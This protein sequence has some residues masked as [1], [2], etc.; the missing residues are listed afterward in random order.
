M[1]AYYKP[2]ALIGQGTYGNVYKCRIQLDQ[3][4]WDT[5]DGDGV[6]AVKKFRKAGAGVDC[7]RRSK[8]HRE[9][10]MV[11]LLSENPQCV[12]IVKLL[13]HFFT[14]GGKL[15]LVFEHI[16]K[17]LLQLIQQHPRGMDEKSAK[18]L[19]W[20][21]LLGVKE[22]HDQNIIH[23]DIKPENV[24]V[25][26]Q[27]VVRLCDFGFARHCPELYGTLPGCR[28]GHQGDGD[29]ASEEMTRY[30]STRWYR[31]PELLL[32]SSSYDTSIDVWAIGCLLIEL[33][34]GRPAF[35]GDTDLHVLSSIISCMGETPPGCQD[36]NDTLV[37]QAKKRRARMDEDTRRLKSW[38]ET[39]SS[40]A[41]DFVKCCLAVCP[42]DRA[43]VDTLLEHAWFMTDRKEWDT[44]D[45]TS[46]IACAISRT[47]SIEA[48]TLACKR[49]RTA[50]AKQAPHRRRQS[51][52][53][54]SVRFY[55][56]Q[57]PP[58]SSLMSHE[59]K[60]LIKH[61]YYT[62]QVQ[63]RDVITR[64]REETPSVSRVLDTPG[65]LPSQ[66]W[67]RAQRTPKPL[68]IPLSSLHSPIKPDEHGLGNSPNPPGPGDDQQQTRLNGKG[69]SSLSKLGSIFQKFFK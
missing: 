42:N 46:S 9:L 33:L 40:H 65:E 10:A 39:S 11:Q 66:T 24:L 44:P 41:R 67:I 54:T 38:L 14:K 55:A 8:C 48:M 18:R 31:A 45:F 56:K 63:Q 53:E 13:D 16:D 20:Q 27:G 19:M 21:L 57:T 51:M 58:S 4:Q 61:A 29:D 34:T 43:T 37:V 12:H 26:K 3:S 49:L 5:D 22:L 62:P 50:T 23:R 47:Q 60:N 35:A 52:K 28:A 25:D 30:V 36:M 59:A 32:R 64:A 68:N 1:D 15:C 17:T 7:H 6:V 69:T 2:I